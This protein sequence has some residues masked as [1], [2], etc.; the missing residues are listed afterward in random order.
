[1]N[2]KKGRYQEL[3][4]ERTDLKIEYIKNPSIQIEKRIV[5]IGKLLIKADKAV[6]SFS[7]PSGNYKKY[8]MDPEERDITTGKLE[9]KK[10]SFTTQIS[11]M[12][13]PLKIGYTKKEILTFESITEAFIYWNDVTEKGFNPKPYECGIDLQ[14]HKGKLY[15]DDLD[16]YD[17]QI[18]VFDLEKKQPTRWQDDFEIQKE[19]IEFDYDATK[20]TLPKVGEKGTFIL[21]GLEEIYAEVMMDENGTAK[22]KVLKGIKKT[23]I[24]CKLESENCQYKDTDG[25]CE[26]H[27]QCDHQKSN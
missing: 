23:K 22:L 12:F 2:T 15:E 8:M 18:F 11:A 27:L 24:T 26:Y 19:I 21:P 20:T 1:M 14:N 5:E 25:N 6:G 17:D 7:T 16:K 10:I 4:E 9:G 13:S 3:A